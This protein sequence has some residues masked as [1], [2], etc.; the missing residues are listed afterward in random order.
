GAGLRA[1]L[2]SAITI[3]LGLFVIF[4]QLLGLHLPMLPE[5]FS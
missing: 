3:S 4:D 5:S 2:V 1:G